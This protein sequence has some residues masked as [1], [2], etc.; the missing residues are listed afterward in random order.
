[1]QNNDGDDNNLL[2]AQLSSSFQYGIFFFFPIYSPG[3][4]KESLNN[5]AEIIGESPL[6]LSPYCSG[7]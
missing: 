1:L 2:V 5:A 4:V 7:C 6:L 3:G